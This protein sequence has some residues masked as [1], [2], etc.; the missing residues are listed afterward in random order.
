[1]TG[2]L[3]D[4]GGARG[5]THP[6]PWIVGDLVIDRAVLD[7]IHAHARECYPSESCGLLSGPDAEAV[8]IDAATREDNEAD[9]YHELDPATFPR[10]SRT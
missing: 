4:A 6:R 10:T 1:M 9:K 8:V 5:A 3:V 2:D 7:G